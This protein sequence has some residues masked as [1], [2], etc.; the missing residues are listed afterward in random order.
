MESHAVSVDTEP[1]TLN[2]NLLVDNA[3]NDIIF[4]DKTCF[5][6]LGLVM[7]KHI[8]IITSSHLISYQIGRA[9]L[10]IP[11]GTRVRIFRGLFTN[12]YKKIIEFLRHSSQWFSSSYS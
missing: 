8:T 9:C 10:V 2:I 7:T 3:T 1:Y 5:L 11:G 12:V 6:Y 4:R